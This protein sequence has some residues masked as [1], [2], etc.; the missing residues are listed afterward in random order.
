MK[1]CRKKYSTNFSD[2]RAQNYSTPGIYDADLK[3]LTFFSPAPFLILGLSTY[4]VLP[5]GEDPSFPNSL[6][7]L[8]DA[9]IQDA[10]SQ[11]IQALFIAMGLANA[12]DEGVSNGMTAYDSSSFSEYMYNYLNP[13]AIGGWYNLYI[14]PTSEIVQFWADENGRTDPENMRA[15]LRELCEFFFQNSSL[16]LWNPP[17]AYII[18]LDPAINTEPYFADLAAYMAANANVVNLYCIQQNSPDLSSG[19]IEGNPLTNTLNSINFA[20]D[21]PDAIL[22][23]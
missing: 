12:Q 6:I 16:P 10:N 15:R 9:A 18:N 13:S 23:T 19:G 20:G 11:W 14:A 21:I 3:T 2:T 7:K 8:P 5:V 17:G 22:W 1:T 4:D